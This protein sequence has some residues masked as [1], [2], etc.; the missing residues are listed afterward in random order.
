MYKTP[1]A[2]VNGGVVIG[3]DGTLY[4]NGGNTVAGEA[5]AGVFAL[6][7]D[8]SLNGIMLQRRTLATACQSSITEDISTSFRTKPSIIL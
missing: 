2:I 3:T 7:S 5:S 4:A 8:G 1:G 6:N